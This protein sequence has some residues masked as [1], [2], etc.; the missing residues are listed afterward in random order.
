MVGG[1]VLPG[2]PVPN[3]YITL[4]G[5]QTYNLTLNLLRDLKLVYLILFCA[6][7]LS[8]HYVLQGQYTKLPPRV[9]F[10][11]QTLGSVIVGHLVVLD[12]E[13]LLMHRSG[14]VGQLCH[15]EVCNFWQPP[16]SP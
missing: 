6:L 12:C 4:Y 8:A 10:I 14:R 9:T 16:N 5:Y 7:F 13:L 1:A 11:A 3:M 2:R 15:Y